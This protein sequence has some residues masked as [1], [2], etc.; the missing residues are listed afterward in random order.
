MRTII[1]GI[2][3][4]PLFAQHRLKGS[5][6]IFQ[7]LDG[8]QIAGNHGL[9]G[10]HHSQ[11]IAL[12]DQLDRLCRS[13][14]QFQLL[15]LV[16]QVHLLRDGP[17]PIQEDRRPLM[18]AVQTRHLPPFHIVTDRIVTVW[19]A[20]I[21]DILKTDVAIEA[22]ACR[23]TSGQHVFLNMTLHAH[24]NLG[25][26][27]GRED[28][29]CGIHDVT[30]DKTSRMRLVIELTHLAVGIQIY[31]IRII[32]MVIGMQEQGGISLF[33]PVIGKHRLHIEIN[34]R[35]AIEHEEVLCELIFQIA[36]C[37]GCSQRLRLLEIVDVDTPWLTITE[38]RGYLIPH[39][40][41]DEKEF[42]EAITLTQRHLMFDDRL[43]ANGN[44]RLRN[45]TV[46]RGDTCPLPAG[47]DDNLRHLPKAF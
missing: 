22:H 5:M 47:Y 16:Q 23:Q 41:D 40:T 38:V 1:D 20:H 3:I 24:L 11:K 4:S 2:D 35:V 8:T 7:F 9:I 6:D 43:P 39:M 27:L 26:D 31:D 37:P 25:Q 46:D 14:D 30:A 19:C 12:V 18:A 44:H 10:N 45:L 17:I 36:Q 42:R 21:L 34:N 13:G 32:R 29:E 15:G 33:L 28:K